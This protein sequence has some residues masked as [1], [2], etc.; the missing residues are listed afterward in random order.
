MI[1]INVEG[2]TTVVLRECSKEALDSL[3]TLDDLKVN[4]DLDI[5][6]CKGLKKL[7][8]YLMVNRYLNLGG[9]TGL[10]KLPDDL[11]VVYLF[12]FGCSGITKL[13]EDLQVKGF[14]YYNSDTGFYGHEYDP[15]VIPERLQRRLRKY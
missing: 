2:H 1:E 13:P 3:G 5:S 15:R 11:M 4:G 10:T 12:L 14:I 9:C 7:P 8:V 6:G